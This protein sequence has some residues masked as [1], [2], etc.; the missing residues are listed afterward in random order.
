[1]SYRFGKDITADVFGA[2]HA[3]E[4]GVE[5]RGLPAGEDIDLAELQAFL[6][7]RKPGGQPGSTG[8]REP[9][10]PEIVSGLKDGATDGKPL[11]AV[12]RNRD[13]RSGDY[14]EL[15]DVP[16]PGHADYTAKVKYGMDYDV[17]GG[18]AF[19]GRM[20][21]PLC[22][23]GGIALQILA[24]RGISVGAHIVSIAGETDPI[25]MDR[26]IEEARSEGDSV[27]GVIECVIEGVPA[28]LGGPMTEGVE[29]RIAAMAFGIPAVKGIEFGA[30][31]RAAEMR[32]SENNDAFYADRADGS[33]KTKTN[34]AGGILGGITNGM[35]VV[36][37]VAV[38]PTPSIAKEQDS[39]SLSRRENVK[40]RVKGR[41]DACIVP[42]AVPVVE[43]VAALAI[44]DLMKGEE[45]L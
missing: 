6:D 12:I 22:I 37:R 7:R 25:A 15:N 3:P 27:G 16:R 43:A 2:S 13:T 31:F 36:F 20:T 39:V 30:G 44:M 10:A 9:D 1:M 28:G 11:R 5:I 21:A 34:N 8:R 33:I 32:G 19:S 35:P 26:A 38:K 45:D 14:S 24:R 17:K 29:S 41:H 23:A 18:G 40:L 4:I 42:R